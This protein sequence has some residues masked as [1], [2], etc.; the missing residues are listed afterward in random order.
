[1]VDC[2]QLR[3][4]TNARISIYLHTILKFDNDLKYIGNCGLF[5]YD[6]RISTEF[7]C[8]LAIYNDTCYL[9]YSENDAAA[10]IVKFNKELITN[11]EYIQ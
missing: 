6:N 9:T 4:E 1:M 7:G 11:L 5:M 10:Y 2:I 3:K 8:G